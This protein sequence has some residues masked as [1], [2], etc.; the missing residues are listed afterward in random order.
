[1]D[2]V[3]WLKNPQSHQ[4]DWLDFTQHLASFIAKVMILFGQGVINAL[5]CPHN[6]SN[7]V[8]SLDY[9]QCPL[10]LQRPQILPNPYHHIWFASYVFDKEGSDHN[11]IIE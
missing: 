5:F 8:P 7:N 4:V 6:S 9:V 10:P 2:L 11:L 3:L 1:M